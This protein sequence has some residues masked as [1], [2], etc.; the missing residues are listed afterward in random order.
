MEDITITMQR[1]TLQHQNK[2]KRLRNSGR[3]PTNLGVL[4]VHQ[5]CGNP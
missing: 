3:Y 5:S 2:N 1:K 4:R